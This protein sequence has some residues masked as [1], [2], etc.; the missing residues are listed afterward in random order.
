SPRS[1]RHSPSTIRP[2]AKRPSASNT[3]GGNNQSARS[4]IAASADSTNPR[5]ISAMYLATA[6][7]SLSAK[8]I[9]LPMAYSLLSHNILLDK[10]LYL[11]KMLL[12]EHQEAEGSKSVHQ[13]R[14]SNYRPSIRLPGR[15]SGGGVHREAA[16][17][18][19]AVL[20]AVRRFRGLSDEE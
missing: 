3:E 16:M 5:T 2:V 20:S 12:H 4:A 15:E 7:C 17:G 13:G 18:R 9:T 1:S 14:Y 10:S 11:C 6:S 19:Q 8:G